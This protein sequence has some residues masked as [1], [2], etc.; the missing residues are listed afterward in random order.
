MDSDSIPQNF[1]HPSSDLL[2]NRPKFMRQASQ[3]F[4][5]LGGLLEDGKPSSFN[6]RS[7]STTLVGPGTSS[8]ITQDFAGYTP[9]ELS[10]R[11]SHNLHL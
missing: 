5:I 6:S 9:P 2:A 4:S 1:F 3:A 7:R 11:G 10:P 8:T